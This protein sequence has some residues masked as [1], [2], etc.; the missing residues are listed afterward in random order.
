[1]LIGHCA[2]KGIKILEEASQAYLAA[3]INIRVDEPFVFRE[4]ED[5]SNN[6]SAFVHPSCDY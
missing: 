1:M 2:S 4:R 5:L 3:G 6:K